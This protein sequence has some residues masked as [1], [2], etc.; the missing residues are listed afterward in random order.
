MRPSEKNL[1]YSGRKEI[2]PRLDVFPGSEDKIGKIQK[3][4]MGD[5]PQI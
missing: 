5:G 4:I 3:S 2:S 1:K